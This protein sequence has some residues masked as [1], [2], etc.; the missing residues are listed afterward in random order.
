MG[1]SRME[2]FSRLGVIK[3]V[4]PMIEAAYERQEEAIWRGDLDSSPHGAPW[5]TSFHASEFPGDNPYA[6]PRAALY[7]LM[8]VPKN[9]PIDRRGRMYM[10]AGK[11][12]ELELVRR[13]GSSGW[14][15]SAD[16]TSGDDYQ[17]NFSD[18]LTWLSGSPDV[19]VIPPGW[20]R[21]HV[22]EIK[23]KGVRRPPRYRELIDPIAEMRSMRE[24]PTEKHVRQIKTYIGLA[25]R[26]FHLRVP[27]V[28]VCQSDWRVLAVQQTAEVVDTPECPTCEGGCQRLIEM[29][30]VVD[31]T[32]LYAAL[33]DATVTHEFL[34]SHDAKGFEEGRRK[35]TAW[36]DAFARGDLP[37]R[38]SDWMWS[39]DPYQCRWCPFK[40]DVCKPDD[41]AGIGRLRDS[42]AIPA[43]AA[44]RPGYDYDATRR[45]VLDRWGSTDKEETDG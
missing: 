45:A 23:G 37:E 39:K 1:I 5:H 31:G 26:E 11:N 30:P 21:G 22:V 4:D 36:K 43:A 33:D 20:D 35:L 6:C 8:N 44:I 9:E 42:H 2:L 12:L 28:W 16:Q 29:R 24:E 40:R 34:Y 17:T 18:D 10:D 41:K 7:T 27:Y 19:I 14:L 15:L 13:F 32:L 25:N 38:P 3:L